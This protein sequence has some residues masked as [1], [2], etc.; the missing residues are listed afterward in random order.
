MGWNLK[1]NR[2]LIQSDVIPVSIK[3]VVQ[4]FSPSA[5]M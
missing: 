3:P 1:S 5:L 2:W 4:L